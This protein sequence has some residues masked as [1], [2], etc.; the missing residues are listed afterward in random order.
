MGVIWFAESNENSGE[1]DYIE[2]K[3]E[4]KVVQLRNNTLIIT[5]LIIFLFVI[6]ANINSQIFIPFSIILILKII[7]TSTTSILLLYEIDKNNAFVKN[8]CGIGGKTNCDAVLNSSASKIAGISWSEIG[9]FYF[10][11][12]T[13][14]LLL[15]ILSSP[16]KF[17]WIAIANVFAFPYVF[18]S[19]YYQWRV[20]KHFSSILT[21]S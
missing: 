2:K 4:E 5:S 12:T 3:K 20:I 11:A 17:T 8:L 6:M 16:I 18:F 7:G 13:I 9:F 21:I 19:I 10:A 15:P 14:G 1:S